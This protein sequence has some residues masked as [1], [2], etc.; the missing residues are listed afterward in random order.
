[1]ASW[2]NAGNGLPNGYNGNREERLERLKDYGQE[3]LNAKKVV[4]VGGGLVGV[5]LAGD[6]AGY[7]KL[8]HKDVDVTLVHSKRPSHE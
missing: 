7:G 5:E 2:T 6:V 8:E 4:I 3:L 1:M